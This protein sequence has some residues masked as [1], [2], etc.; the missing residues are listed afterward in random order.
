V[1]SV[2][3]KTYIPCQKHGCLSLH[4]SFSTGRHLLG[5]SSITGLKLICTAPTTKH[6]RKCLYYLKHKNA[7]ALQPKVFLTGLL[8]FLVTRKCRSAIQRANH[9]QGHLQSLVTTCTCKYQENLHELWA[10]DTWSYTSN[11]SRF[12]AKQNVKIV[13]HSHVLFCHKCVYTLCAFLTFS[14]T[15]LLIGILS[16]SVPMFTISSVFP[17]PLWATCILRLISSIYGIIR[18]HENHPN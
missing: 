6:Y 2:R 12:V 7:T 16:L 4:D 3:D 14:L 9:W 10:I 5:V 8:R 15:H 18:D 17:C 1:T 11:F 13:H